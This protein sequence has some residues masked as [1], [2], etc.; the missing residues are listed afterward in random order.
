[1]IRCPQCD[2]KLCDKLEGEAKFTCPR[3]K[4]EF[5]AKADLIIGR[6]AKELRSPGMRMTGI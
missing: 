4:C 2:K 3:C 5:K 6:I 1:M